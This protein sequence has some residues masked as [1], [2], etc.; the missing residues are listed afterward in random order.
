MSQSKK[1]TAGEQ[2]SLL[3]APTKEPRAAAEPGAPKQFGS[4]SEIAGFTWAIADLLRGDFKR[5]EYGQVNGSSGG[6]G[7]ARLPRG[8]QWRW[9]SSEM[10]SRASLWRLAWRAGERIWRSASM[11]S[12]ARHARA[13][14]RSPNERRARTSRVLQ[15]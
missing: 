2:L 5:H 10:P 6:R 14:P 15:R 1:S 3:D 7:V 12:I 8:G 4:F 13:S 11:R 9:R